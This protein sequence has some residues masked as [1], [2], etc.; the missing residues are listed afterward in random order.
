MKKGNLT[1]EDFA[2]LTQRI[3]AQSLK[4]GDGQILEAV[5]KKTF[6]IQQK[7][8]EG[9][10]TSSKQLGRLMAIARPKESDD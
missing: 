7:Y 9:K 3:K 5:L 8:R 6:L 4:K 2:G 1:L 10:I